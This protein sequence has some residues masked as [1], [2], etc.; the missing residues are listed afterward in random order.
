MRFVDSMREAR[1]KIVLF[2]TQLVVLVAMI[3][4]ERG[5]AKVDTSYWKTVDVIKPLEAVSSKDQEME[6]VECKE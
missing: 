3:T 4:G 2:L 1:F 5:L 6:S